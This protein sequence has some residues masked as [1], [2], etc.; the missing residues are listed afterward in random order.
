MSAFPSSVPTY[1]YPAD[2]VNGC[3]N[4]AQNLQA[5]AQVA[6][7]AGSK[8]LVTVTPTAALLN[9]GTGHT[10]V[11]FW[12][13]LPKQYCSTG[14]INT[15][16][17]C[18]INPEIT[19]ALGM[20]NEIW[21]YNEQE[22][23]YYSPKWLLDFP[24]INYRIF[25]GFMNKRFGFTGMMYSDVAHWSSDAWNNVQNWVSGGYTFP[26]DGVLVYPGQ[27]VGLSTVVPAMRLKYVRDG[28]DD[29]DYMT[30]LEQQGHGALVQSILNTVAPDW[31]NWTQSTATLQS[32]RI[33]MGQELDALAGGSGSP[34][35]APSNPFPPSASTGVATSLNVV[36][37]AVASATKY[38]VYFG[39]NTSRMSLWATVNAPTVRQP[40]YNLTASSTYYWRIV[41]I[42]GSSSTSG[43]TWS[44][45]T[46]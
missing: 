30:M 11:D 23:D 6:H 15:T 8:T 9:D 45:T 42:N 26:G 43:P 3:P 36:W 37:S 10:D 46:K 7:A 20:G 40:F 5:W 27:Q 41:A 38:Q 12:A 19:A 32:A 17:T 39:N 35:A 31:I 34:L 25:P 28:I 44:F 21:S 13:L 1:V 4:L 2:E 24:P 14:H 18:V 33:E 16:T 22:Q 29:Y